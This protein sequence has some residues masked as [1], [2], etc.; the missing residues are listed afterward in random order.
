[1][2][3]KDLLRF[4]LKI[5]RI[6]HYQKQTILPSVKRRPLFGLDNDPNE[7]FWV[8]SEDFFSAISRAG[9]K[10]SLTCRRTA[11]LGKPTSSLCYFQACPWECHSYGNPMGNVPW[12][13]TGIN[14]YGMGMGEINMSHEQPCF[15]LLITNLQRFEIACRACLSHAFHKLRNPRLSSPSCSWLWI[16]FHHFR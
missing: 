8:E 15:F 16:S 9:L 12:D 2:E 13:G 5:V 3:S 1:V 6:G 10:R 11:N 4:P 14:C 7:Q